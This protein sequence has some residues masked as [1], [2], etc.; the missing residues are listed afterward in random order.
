M[1]RKAS[2]NFIVRKENINGVGDG[3]E[4]VIRRRV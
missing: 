1:K 3:G 4:G 2:W